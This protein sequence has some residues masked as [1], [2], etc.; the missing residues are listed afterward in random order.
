[1]DD[2]DG[3]GR[4][5]RSLYWCVRTCEGGREGGRDEWMDG[6]KGKSILSSSSVTAPPSL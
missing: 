6:W 2:D 5:G 3:A 4:L 1:M